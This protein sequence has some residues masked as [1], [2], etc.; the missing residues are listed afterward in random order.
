MAEAQE[1][2]I[3]VSE[4]APMDQPI[5]VDPE[6]TA[7]FIGRAPC[8]P[9]D[10]PVLVTGLND[11]HRRFGRTGPHARLADAVVQFFAHGGRRA[12]VVRVA[13]N[14]RGAMLCLPASPG[15]LVLRGTEPGSA[16]RIR[17]A[18]DYDRIPADDREHFNLTLQRLAPDTGLVVDQEIHLRLSCNP[19]DR[20]YVGTALAA[21]GIARPQRPLPA[22]RP[23]LTGSGN[24]LDP[25]YVEPA[26]PG[27]DGSDLTDYDLVGCAHRGTGLFA[28]EQVERFDFLYLPPRAADRQPGP[29][30]L[31][32]AM[33]Y[34]RRRGAMLVMDP[35]REWTSPREAIEGVRGAGFAS[36]DVLT[37]F[38]GLVDRDTGAPRAA[39]AALAGLLC[40][41]DRQLGAWESIDGS[42]LGFDRRLAPALTL[43]TSE[44]RRLVKAGFNV[45]TVAAGGRATLAGS[46]TLAC[47]THLPADFAS[48]HVRRLC[49]SMTAAIERATR[50][51]V[52]EPDGTR[53]AMRIRSQIHAYLAWLAASGALADERFSV[54]C[55]AALHAGRREPRRGVTILLSFHPA[56]AA[57]R[58]SLTL[59][60]TPS[61]C[62]VT[63]SA[64]PP[65]TDAGVGQTGGP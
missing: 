63:T 49:L 52:F 40:R 61:G 12:Y 17:A 19:D 9:I 54:S 7:A 27:S 30:A 43:T 2:G 6:T 29:A 50:W 62:R 20:G 31:V 13:N 56:G 60:Q 53:L 46:V 1:R 22:G 28:L 35:A 65:A 5:G 58:L 15:V 44:A 25:G 41:H 21:S 39:G 57:E 4:I 8:G 47:N 11:F 64:F 26:Q 14:A 45:V 18:V 10:T 51:A 55:D 38:P 16:E 42:L 24:P 34:C 59:H 37:C 23:L 33:L 32:A 3:T 48:L 36:P